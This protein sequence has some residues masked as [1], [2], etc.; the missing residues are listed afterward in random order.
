MGM[1]HRVDHGVHIVFDAMSPQFAKRT[2]FS[3]DDAEKIKTVLTKL[4]EG[5]ASFACP[6][7]NVEVMKLI[8]L[9]HNCKAG[10]YSSTKVH[11]SLK[12]DEDSSYEPKNLEDLVS[13]QIDG[14]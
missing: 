13:Q 10:Q 12:E 9:E 3:D 7:G 2:G 1:K 6:E 8:W 5:D 11:G 4:F 14:L